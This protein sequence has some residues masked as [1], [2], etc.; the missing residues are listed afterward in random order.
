MRRRRRRAAAQNAEC[1]MRGPGETL[2]PLGQPCARV[3]FDVYVY[4]YVAARAAG[5]QVRSVA[6]HPQHQ[7]PHPSHPARACCKAPLA[8]LATLARPVTPSPAPSSLP[9]Y[10]RLRGPRHVRLR[11][12]RPPSAAG[13]RCVALVAQRSRSPPQSPR[14]PRPAM[15][16]NTFHILGDVSHTSS[17]L[18]LLW[19][20]HSNSS[21]EGELASSPSQPSTHADDIRPQVSPSSPRPYMPSSSALAILTSSPYRP[22]RTSGTHGTFR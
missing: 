19:A 21:T 7:H 14:S 11:H 22:R 2:V 18:I 4:V 13:Q 10:T 8:A 15:K 17:K 16:F 1:R 12:N 5:T 6:I 3:P 9:R 20:I